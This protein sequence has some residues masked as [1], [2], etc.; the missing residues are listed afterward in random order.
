MRVRGTVQGVGF[1]PF[2]YRRAVALGLSGFVGNDADGVLLEV[3][4]RSEDVDAL[5]DCLRD[6]PPPLALV[7]AVEAVGVPPRG[8]TGFTV[9]ATA[10][11]D[12]TDVHVST[13]I[14]P[15]EPCLAELRDPADRRYRYPFVNCTDCGPRYTIVRA[16]PYDRPV[17]TM[18]DFRMCA[19]CQAEYDDPADRRFHAQ[20]NACP[21]CG[22]T[23]AW[24]GPGDGDD[25]VESAAACLQAGGIVA[26]KGV[27]G[28]HLACDAT[29]EHAVAALRERKRRPAKPLAV[30]VADLAAAEALCALDDSSRDALAS[31]RRPVVLVPRRPG[32]ALAEAVAPGLPEL[33][34]MLPSSP[35]HELLLEAVRRPLVMTS[36]NRS[37]EPVLHRDDEARTVL[38][39]VADGFLAH[40]R[41]V[42]VRVDDSV[43]RSRRGLQPQMVRRARGWVPQPLR[44]P[45]AASRPVLAV[46]A[47]LKSTVA[48]VRGT[49]VVM[50]QHLGDLGSYPAH[51]AFREAI[52]HLTRLSGVDPAVVAHDLHPDYGSTAWALASG[53]PLL[54]VQHH[55]AHIAACLAEH[56]VTSTVLGIAFDGVG[57]GTDGT[58]WGG[59]L[60]LADLTGFTR[61]GHLAPAPLPGGDVA[62][63]EPWRMALA[64]L[65]RH[66]GAD[67]AAAHGPRFDDRWPAVLSLAAS[68]RA[69]ET[70]SVGRLFDGVAALLGV[71]DR[72]TYDGQAAVELEAL[73]RAAGSSPTYSFD[74]RAGRLDPAPMLTALLA[75]RA[76]GVPVEQL[77]AG[78]HRGLAEAAAHA[79]VELAGHAGV[80]TVALSGGVFSNVLLS[81]LLAER[82]RR[83][84]LH[85]LQHAQLPPNDGGISAGQAAVAAATLS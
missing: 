52:D 2:V 25:A 17:T 1:R 24:S 19:L 39:P 16:V 23:A 59:E 64:L 66:L 58:L 31:A 28:Y 54:A 41:P 9:A 57:L 80:D 62:V 8:D 67:V 83:A 75:D 77:A 79:A 56:G 61:V 82:L 60:L 72:I 12:V 14:A 3:E 55:H 36:G 51:V 40:D 69:P 6:E 45:L 76:A 50:S 49:S 21:A 74:V 32:A 38:A 71:R 7:E 35:L 11:G 81:E 43:V 37:G 84:G 53:L 27:G 70:T 5:V 18:R 26:V 63:R 46:G 4:G 48:L 47:H 78:F 30:M 68:G 34:L 10:A 44:L 15:C 29:S 85:V 13:D 73:A 33:G 65:Q 42:H 22:P 20:P